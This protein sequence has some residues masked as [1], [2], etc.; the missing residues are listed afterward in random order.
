MTDCIVFLAKGVGNIP[1]VWYL[2]DHCIVF[3]AKGVSNIP[4]V[5]YPKGQYQQ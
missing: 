5:R 2:F 1:V 3:L 4:V